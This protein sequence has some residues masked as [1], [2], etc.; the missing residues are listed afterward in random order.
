MGG[1]I[2]AWSAFRG[3]TVTL[4]DRSEELIQPAHAARQG[5]FRQAAQGAAGGGRRAGAAAD[6]RARRRRGAR[7]TSSSR[8]FSRTSRPSGRCMPSSNPSSNRAPFLR[9]IPRAS[10][11]KRWPRSSRDPSRLVGIHFF[12]PVAQ[13]Q[14]VEIVQG[15]GTQAA[16]GARRSALHAQARQAAAAL[17]ERAGLRRQ[18]HSDALHQR[19][20]VR[21]GEAASPPPSSTAPARTSACPW[22]RSNSTDVVGLDVSLHVG[23]VLARGLAAARARRS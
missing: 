20:A 19:S 3:M 14:L 16:G 9:P 6:G 8:P 12:N 10:R 13:M 2:A 23:R 11:S 22:D 21:A 7:P 17:Q 1:D 15:A 18:P 4:Q 5:L